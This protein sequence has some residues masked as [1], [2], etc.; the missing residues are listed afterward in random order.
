[1]DLGHFEIRIDLG[2]DLDQVPV[3]AQD[4]QEGTE[5]GG[6]AVAGGDDGT[7]D[8]MAGAGWVGLVRARTR[9]GW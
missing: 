8:A 6:G 5:I 9:L 2:V 4:G 1:M 3:L 7:P